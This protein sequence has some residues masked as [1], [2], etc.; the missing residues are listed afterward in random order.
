MHRLS[1]NLDHIATLRQVRGTQYPDL[2]EA[3]RLVQV[4]GADGITLHLR[5]DRRHIQPADVTLIRAFELPLTLE[6]A[7]SAENLKYCASIRPH[8]VT[9]VPERKE[10]LSTEGGLN[11]GAPGLKEFVNEA[12]LSL[13]DAGVICCLF[14]EPDPETI[15]AAH[16]MGVRMIELHTGT[17]AEATPAQIAGELERIQKASALGSSLGIQMNAGHGLTVANVVPFAAD[18]NLFEFSIGHSIVCRSVF[19]G[20]KAAVQEMKQAIG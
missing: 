12:V 19:V 20:L 2:L 9:F 6:I 8:A 7:C 5:G 15:R 13:K 11:L 18:K 4:A 14:L 3:A 10:E 17:Y 1:V 16:A